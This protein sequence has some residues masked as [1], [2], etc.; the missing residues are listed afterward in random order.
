MGGRLDATNLLDADVALVTAIGIDHT[1][2]LGPDRESIA[3]EKA[4][5]FRRG[6]PAVCGDP[7]PPRSL[8]AHAQS[9]GAP[10]YRLGH[11]FGY[12]GAHGD[13]TWSWWGRQGGVTQRFDTLP[14]PRLYG[15]FQLQNAAGAVMALQQ[16]A[17]RFPV[18]EQALREGLQT[19]QV[20][21]RF[22]IVP[23]AV[24]C[25]FDVA[26][27]PHGAEV[28]AAT[29][30]EHACAGRTLAVC[31]MLADKDSA[32]VLHALRD[33]VDSW[34]VAGLA[35]PRGARA[36]QLAAV[37]ST[38]GA[39]VTAHNNVADACRAALRDAR[40]GDRVVAFGSFYTVAE[41]WPALQAAHG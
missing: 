34:Y 33:S 3:R 15:A 21:G 4:G 26:H 40:P 2:Y 1:A 19:A 30:R 8:I 14:R 27:N 29:L 18:S 41:A 23:G 31:A 6:R 28:L 13:G 11:D 16:C 9:L 7:D 32:G 17:A 39:A 12:E 22:Q 24:T 20:R 37:L 5:I 36:E 25:I 35:A 10:L 38:A